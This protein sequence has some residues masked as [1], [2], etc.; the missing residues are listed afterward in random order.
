[1]GGVVAL[2][3]RRL[4]SLFGASLEALQAAN[5]R[6]LVSSS[7]QEAFDLDF[8][9]CLYGRGDS[10]RRA[11]AGDVAAMANTAGGVIVLGVAEDG[12]ARA[13]AAPGVQ[14]TD[15]E[16]ARIRQVIAS[17]V[18]PMPVVDVLAVPGTQTDNGTGTG[19]GAA[20]TGTAD[21]NPADTAEDE[22]GHGF[23]VIAVPRS[24]A[25]PHAVL[26]NDALRYPR[27]NGA[28][29]RY[30][31][32]P[33]VAAAYRERLTGASRQTARI[34]E[35]GQAALERLD[36][37]DLPWVAVT[38]VPD[39]P[40]DLLITNDAYH[41]FRDE[42]TGQPATIIANNIAFRRAS[43]GPRRLLADG[44]MNNSPL[45]RWVSL[46]LHADGSGAYA[47]GVLDLHERHRMNTAPEGGPRPQMIQ[48]EALVI[49]VL[50]GVLQLARH[51]RDRA[52]AGGSALLHAQIYPVSPQRPTELGHLQPPGFIDALG[53]RVL[54]AQPPA[55]EAVAQLDDLAQPSP[56][57][58]QASALL[59]SGI[60]HAFGVAEL[61]HLSREGQI[62]R[63]YWAHTPITAWAEQHG[64]EVTENTL[65]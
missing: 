26:V 10:D 14:V 8:K 43:V 19:P 23:I 28:T 48:D 62:R 22:Q 35:V 37:Q 41:A 40:G 18:A 54:S 42:V 34:T 21:G 32:E 64:I 33:E 1:M 11:L 47:A 45:A 63:R 9:A 16:V 57:L 46:D 5:V 36:D 20:G 3:S 38:L 13:A 39:L 29:T 25:A 50:S 4:E 17:L 31:S 58:V 53:T 61:G 2:R 65:A 27:R 59:I 49:A 24:P 30:L 12:Q 7:A 56:A 15:A 44:T 6:A 52:A 51:S 55:A 60:G